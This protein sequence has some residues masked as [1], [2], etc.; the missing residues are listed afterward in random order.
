MLQLERVQFGTKLNQASELILASS[1]AIVYLFNII[2]CD[3]LF[4]TRYILSYVIDY[5][6]HIIVCDRLFIPYHRINP[7]SFN[8]TG[9][10]CYYNRP[11]NILQRLHCDWRES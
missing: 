10:P 5:L 9:Y 8:S 7:F 11:D 2:V 3:R 1:F 6:F 4:I